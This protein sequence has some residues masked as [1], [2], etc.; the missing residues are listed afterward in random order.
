MFKKHRNYNLETG[1]KGSAIAIFN[2]GKRIA[3]VY[4]QTIVVQKIG[5]KVTLDNGGW[6]TISTRH[7]INRALEQMATSVCYLY[8]KKGQTM[9]TQNGIVKPFNGRM[10]ITVR[11]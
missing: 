9:L 2:Q 6:D 10:T 1:T 7:V 5:R 8:R 3:V 11:Q 4:H